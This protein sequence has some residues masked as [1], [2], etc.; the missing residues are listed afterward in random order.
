MSDNRWRM[1]DDLFHRALEIPEPAR[2]AFLARACGDD[3]ALRGQIETL[4]RSDSRAGG[5]LETPAIG[6]LASPTE[7]AAEPE[8]VEGLRIGSYRLVRLLG[9]GGMGSVYLGE[10]DDRQFTQRAAIKLIKRG[11]DTEEIVRRFR[12]E[13]QTLANLNHPNICRLLDGG[14]TDDDRPYLV[15]EHI[16]G[17]RIDEYCDRRRLGVTRRLELFRTVCGA[18]QYAHQNLVVHRDL[19]PGNIL[20]TPEGVPKLLDFGISKVLHAGAAD[21]ATDASLPGSRPLTP[22]YASPEQVAGGPIT[23]ASDVYSLGVILYELLTGRPRFPETPS[24]LSPPGVDPR[25]ATPERPSAAVAR[26]PSAGASEGDGTAASRSTTAA[27]LRRRLRGDLDTIVLAAL[28]LEPERRYHSAQQLG[29]DVL[30]HLDGLPVLARPDTLRYR[31][32]KFV[33]RHRIG[34]AL[35]AAAAATLAAAAAVSTTS[36]LAA[37][38]ARDRARLEA[39]K[40][41]AVS[42]FLHDM[43]ISSDPAEGS[44][45]DTTVREVLDAAAARLARHP[46]GTPGVEPAVQFTIGRT[47]EQLGLYEEGGIHLT[48][49]L[50]LCRA[51]L[52]ESHPDTIVAMRNLGGLRRMQDRFDE[53]EALLARA[54]ELAPRVFGPEHEETIATMNDLGMLR[55][56]LNRRDEAAAIY[57]RALAL[58]LGALGPEHRTVMSLLNNRATILEELGRVAE[59]GD[60]YREALDARVRVLGESDTRSITTMNNYGLFLRRHGSLDEAESLLTRALA[61]GT[62]ALT[63]SHPVTLTTMHNLAIVLQARGRLDDA[64]SILRTVVERR[65]RVLSP[66]HRKTL[67]SVNNL[68]MLL[69]ARDKPADAEPLLRRAAESLRVSLGPTHPNFLIVRSNLAE[70]IERQGRLDDALPI[71]RETLEAGRTA[72]PPGHWRIA[73]LEAELGRCLVSAESYPE[74]EP[75]LL[76]AYARLRESLGERNARAERVTTQ[77]VRLYEAWG[78]PEEAAKFRPSEEP[79]APPGPPDR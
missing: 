17:E 51:Q 42:G 75:L 79:A 43:L 30:R 33:R 34:V 71:H 12:A 35:T 22:R 69:L 6:A 7:R 21:G 16:E 47:Y 77:V 59:A 40:A 46:I 56:A 53:A 44:G 1:V 25:V 70:S 24:A 50:D 39:D 5:F 26:P 74:A 57:D 60:A 10:R 55:Q 14:V 11:M 62:A 31:A 72:Y 66:E 2:A 15:M 19:K 20:V 8:S 9:A 68:A 52:G 13:R 73:E 41:G 38:N 58:G 18:V 76:G 65:G 49:A 32:G 48:R 29:D 64:E 23:T 45:P 36:A 4:L 78:R 37:A 67:A 3:R 54:N 63:D 27:R 28:R 61:I